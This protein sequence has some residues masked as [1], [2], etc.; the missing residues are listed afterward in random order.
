[1]NEKLYKNQYSSK[2]SFYWVFELKFVC[3]SHKSMEA[4]SE[5]SSSEKRPF[6]S[7]GC[8]I[9]EIGH[10]A[11]LHLGKRFASNCDRI[12]RKSPFSGFWLFSA[13]FALNLPVL[14]YKCGNLTLAFSSL[15]PMTTS[16]P[17]LP[18]MR[19]ACCYGFHRAVWL[20]N[21]LWALTK[22]LQQVALAFSII[23][24]SVYISS[25]IACSIL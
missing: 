18:K 3:N 21:S 10:F 22:S 20:V 9:A 4:S 6:D 2:S 25:S 8:G 24:L 19:F 1:M 23:P 15:L 14:S 11:D 5:L 16:G 17:T 12:Y 13:Y 7:G